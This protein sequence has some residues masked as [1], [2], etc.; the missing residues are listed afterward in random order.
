[1][2]KITSELQQ[3]YSTPGKNT[4][5]DTMIPEKKMMQYF[6]NFFIAGK[7]RYTWHLHKQEW[8]STVKKFK[9]TC[10]YS[11]QQNYF[12]I[13]S[14]TDLLQR[15]EPGR[16]GYLPCS[17]HL[18]SPCIQDRQALTQLS[19]PRSPCSSVAA[20]QKSCP[21]HSHRSE[22]GSDPAFQL[23]SFSDLLTATTWCCFF[24]LTRQK[25]FLFAFLG[26]VSLV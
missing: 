4:L 14:S 25:Y 2:L 21:L 9:I 10:P 11:K 12:F 5:K 26:T 6:H 23:Y 17:H 13:P 24:L 7:I 1:M 15:T 19:S 20:A 22:A 3:F 8:I 18:H 16:A